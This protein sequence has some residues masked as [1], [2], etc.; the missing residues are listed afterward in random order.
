[1]IVKDSSI[2]KVIVFMC[3]LLGM[4]NMLQLETRRLFSV[5]GA[6]G[7]CVMLVQ[8]LTLPYRFGFSCLF[9][10]SKIVV[11]EERSLLIEYSMDKS[12]VESNST[13][14]LQLVE[15]REGS[16]MGAKSG[17]GREM[18]GLKRD[19]KEDVTLEDDPRPE[20][21]SKGDSDGTSSADKVIYPK[22]IFSKENATKIDSEEL[23]PLL[24]RHGSKISRNALLTGN[25]TVK[26]M[27]CNM[28]PKT[29]MTISEMNSL[30]LRRRASAGLLVCYPQYEFPLCC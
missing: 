20:N 6:L 10:D 3:Y 23:K 21:H 15:F 2:F 30:L 13:V 17:Q 5:M 9:P 16:G 22:K 28:P 1:M 14:H 12:T 7:I 19:I 27:R 29:V 8:T 24:L 25:T 26:P 11:H 4:E 18:E